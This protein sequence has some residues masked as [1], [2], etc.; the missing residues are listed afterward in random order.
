M[1]ATAL[2]EIPRIAADGRLEGKAAIVTGGGSSGRLAG[3]G[4]ATAV[5]LAAKG[6]SVL[7]ADRDEERALNT[8]Y[9]IERGEY[10]GSCAVCCADIA[11]P[12]ACARVAQTAVELFGRLDILVN[13]AAIAPSEVALD[14]KLW[15]EVLTLNLQAPKLMI[16]AVVPH[17]IARGGGAVVNVSSTAALRGG[18]GIAYS[19]AKSGLL[20][21]TRAMAFTY[22]RSG[23]RINSV[24]PG[25][26]HT[27][28]GFGSA[29][30]R[31]QRAAA[32]LL[33]TEGTAWDV[34][35]AVLFLASDEA[36][37][38]TAATLPVDA[39]TTEVAPLSI[40]PYI[41]SAVEAERHSLR[42]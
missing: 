24:A 16:D 28:M 37:W 11:Q 26:V 34:A 23:I 13:N 1:R 9:E 14:G 15:Q 21:L 30:G 4:A 40:F 7:I 3:I 18:G 17:M 36:R 25:H 19:A 33:D 41:A 32:G 29:A 5:L 2:L 22:G 12:D 20:G 8:A 42:S 38:I 35:Y 39:G 31:S 27:P 6:A 10:G